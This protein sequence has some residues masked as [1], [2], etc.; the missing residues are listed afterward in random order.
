MDCRSEAVN[1]FSETADELVQV[2]ITV[3]VDT[4][5]LKGEFAHGSLTKWFSWCGGA[6]SRRQQVLDYA[7]QNVEDYPQTCQLLLLC[8]LV[9]ESNAA[10]E[11][12][13]STELNF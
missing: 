1:N 10:P 8:G 12:L 7:R 5:Q 2:P 13:F 11:R 4:L 6:V 3:P 9:I